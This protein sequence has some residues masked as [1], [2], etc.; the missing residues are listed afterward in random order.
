MVSLIIV[1]GVPFR[2]TVSLALGLRGPAIQTRAPSVQHPLVEIQFKL[3][4]RTGLIICVYGICTDVLMLEWMSGRRNVTRNRLQMRTPGDL[5]V[6]VDLSLTSNNLIY[7]VS[8]FF[9]SIALVFTYLF[10]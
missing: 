10:F 6:Y 5:C 3:I 4:L 8:G 2:H 1:I 7:R 9:I